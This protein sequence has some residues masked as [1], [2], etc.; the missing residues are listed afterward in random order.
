[1]DRERRRELT[2]AYKNRHPQMGV[3]EVRCKA[4]GDV[5][6]APARDTK[7]A[8]NGARFQLELGSHRNREL[9][10]LWKEHGPESFEFGVARE[11]KYDD[12]AEDHSGELEELL[13]QCL[14]E[15]GASKL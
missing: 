1:M 2:E 4:T 13:E 12:P 9:M 7:A 5:F 11:L 3:I 14:A 6:Y 8:I 15:P 10:R